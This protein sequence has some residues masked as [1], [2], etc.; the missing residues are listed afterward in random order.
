[1]DNCQ[2]SEISGFLDFRNFWIS[3][4]SGSQ[5]F[6]KFLDFGVEEG[7]GWISVKGQKILDFRK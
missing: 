3:G 7:V 4:I 6:H 2:R 5:E 1:V